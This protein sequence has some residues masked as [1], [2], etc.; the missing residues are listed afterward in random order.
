MISKTDYTFK[1]LIFKN[2]MLSHTYNNYLFF[3]ILPTKIFFV[4]P[5]DWPA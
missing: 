4:S 3:W 1:I 2:I 5:P